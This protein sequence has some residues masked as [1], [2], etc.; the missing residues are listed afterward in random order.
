M[1]TARLAQ[2][3]IDHI[4][5]FLWD[6]PP[7]LCKCALTHSS[8]YNRS[9]MLLYIRVHIRDCATFS[10][11]RQLVLH[12]P[13]PRSFFEG[14]S[15]L[16]DLTDG[17]VR[18]Y[19]QEIP[20][21]LVS[22][23]QAIRTIVLREA[24]WHEKRSP[25]STFFSSLA[26]LTTITRLELISCT[27]GTFR[28]FQRLLC[29]LPQL[30][31]VSIQDISIKSH[32]PIPVVPGVR[33]TGDRLRLHLLHV[34]GLPSDEFI[35]LLNWIRST[36]SGC[37]RTI[38]SLHLNPM[39]PTT[40]NWHI[41]AGLLLQALGAPLTDVAVPVLIG[42]LSQLYLIFGSNLTWS[43]IDD[44]HAGLLSNSSL[45]SLRLFYLFVGPW[46]IAWGHIARTL[47]SISS[48]MIRHLYLDFKVGI[49]PRYHGIGDMHV[50]LTMDWTPLNNIT[51]LKQFA[52]LTE[53]V[54]GMEWHIS[55][56]VT[57]LEVQD[58]QNTI[59]GGLRQLH[60]NARGILTI[61]HEVHTFS[62]PPS[63]GPPTDVANAVV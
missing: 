6:D 43:S 35:E 27:F 47:F 15:S 61:K 34:K 36:P 1:A 25:H 13:R 62:D 55:E 44:D 14:H 16:L 22:C 46:T 7:S 2:E 41:T 23:R 12:A 60:W 9:R 38:R 40:A 28:E 48:T 54:V 52:S 21:L 32:S 33:S 49:D 39:L 10:A 53:V 57:E 51:M 5:D 56:A 3:I 59:N 8:W 30:T 63:T 50:Q 4:I 19:V 29:E 26:L 58:L 24:H 20:H 17:G 42:G 18:P 37:D 11:F 45:Q 31:E